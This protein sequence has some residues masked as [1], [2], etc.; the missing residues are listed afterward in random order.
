MLTALLLMS[1]TVSLTNDSPA[2][3]HV[4]LI[5]E[6]ELPSRA[7]EMADRGG[8]SRSLEKPSLVLPIVLLSAALGTLILGIV[9]LWYA[10]IIVG[11]LIL[12]GT[13]VLGIIGTI[14]L[15]SRLKGP[16]GPAAAPVEEQYTPPPGPPPPP[17]PAD[18]PPGPP[19]P[20]P[21][22]LSSWA[23]STMTTVAIF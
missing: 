11:V 1:C 18:Q 12:S 21:P 4:R 3:P 20:P 8:G 9:V 13:I 16:S 10:S 14:S 6:S 5:A 23:P 19:P 17:P 22:P 15:V 2:Y 7:V